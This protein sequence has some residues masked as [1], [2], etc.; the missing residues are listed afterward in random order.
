MELPLKFS[1]KLGKCSRKYIKSI[2]ILGAYKL[3]YIYIYMC[4]CVSVYIYV[5]IWVCSPKYQSHRK[6]ETQ[7]FHCVRSIWRGGICFIVLCGVLLKFKTEV[8]LFTLIIHTWYLLR[9]LAT[10]L[11]LRV[12]DC[13][14][15]A[16]SGRKLTMRFVKESRRT[17]LNRLI[18]V[19][20]HH[21]S[22]YL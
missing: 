6:N 16:R 20:N 8:S 12:I 1:L 5:Y 17:H 19:V 14:P 15:V 10:A 13:E 9:I 18:I 4:L 2:W 11:K 22:L 7:P 21:S 3:I